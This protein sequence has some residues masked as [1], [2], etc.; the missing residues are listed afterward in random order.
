PPYDGAGSRL[1]QHGE[2]NNNRLF[3]IAAFLEGDFLMTYN[4]TTEILELADKYKFETESIQM[5]GG[6]N[7]GKIELLIGRNLSWIS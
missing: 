5:N 3:E 4:K 6:A 2:V 7:N 1:Y